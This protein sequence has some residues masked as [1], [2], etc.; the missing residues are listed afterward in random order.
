[1]DTS[2]STL[3]D[4]LWSA[5][6]MVAEADRKL[7]SLKTSEE[8]GCQYIIAEFQQDS[9]NRKTVFIPVPKEVASDLP[10]IIERVLQDY[11]PQAQHAEQSATQDKYNTAK[12]ARWSI[13]AIG[14]ISVIIAAHQFAWPI[15]KAYTAEKLFNQGTAM[16]NRQ[17][18]D[19]A[20]QIYNQALAEDEDF[21]E[22]YINLGQIMITRGQ[23]DSALMMFDRALEFRPGYDLAVY[24]R[25][26]AFT[27]L[28]KY[29]EAITAYRDYNALNGGDADSFVYLADAYSSVEQPDSA[30]TYYIKAYE[31]GYRTAGLSF[32]IGEYQ[33]EANETARAIDSYFE[34]VQQDSTFV[35]A[36]S[37]LS[38]LMQSQ[39]KMEEAAF[40]LQKSE[41]FAKE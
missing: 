9:K 13:A 21:P 24:N 10:A 35:D 25:G 20:F 4:S 12:I 23:P 15:Y 41:L 27:I 33:R 16:F 28:E 3:S 32:I 30:R 18:Y 34:C 22:V 37:R 29:G 1:M 5:F 26:Y 6:T 7:L 17:A 39:G 2:H 40:Y 11:E 36:W 8:A 14:V 38:Q 31:A 19:S